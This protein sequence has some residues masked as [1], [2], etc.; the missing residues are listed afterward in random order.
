MKTDFHLELIKCPKCG[1]KQWGKVEHTTP[2]YSYVHRC[3]SC[4]YIIMESEWD[5]VNKN[6]EEKK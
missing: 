2:W 4:E 5:K 1:V 6:E 3:I